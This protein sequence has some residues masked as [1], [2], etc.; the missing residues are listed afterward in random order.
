MRLVA[1]TNRDLHAL[2]GEG[3]FRADLYYRLSALTLTV[4]PLRERVSDVAA[5][6]RHF[7]GQYAHKFGKRF[8]RVS[9]EALHA[10]ER[11]RWP[12]NVRELKAVLQRA[13]LMSDGEELELAHLPAELVSA[14]VDPVPEALAAGT[15][16]GGCAEFVQREEG[17]TRTATAAIRRRRA[18][19]P[20]SDG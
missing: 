5:L 11:W 8:R 10:L 17:V 20:A 4:P 1:A 12:G 7:V 9:E 6:A 15:A 19:W 16:P 13:V 3:K 2:V 14:G 18:A